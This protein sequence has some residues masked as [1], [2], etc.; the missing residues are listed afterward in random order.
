MENINSGQWVCFYIVLPTILF[1]L[2]CS[3]LG[4]AFFVCLFV[5]LPRTAKPHQTILHA[6]VSML[7]ESV[8]D[9]MPFV[10]TFAYTLDGLAIATKQFYSPLAS[11][12][13][14][15]QCKISI[16]LPSPL[17]EHGKEAVAAISLFIN[18]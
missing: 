8:V 1:G 13:S 16:S 12:G 2:I 3:S 6:T 9:N 7:Y 10:T 18:I 4:L 15:S 14:T 5:A 11:I 17:Y